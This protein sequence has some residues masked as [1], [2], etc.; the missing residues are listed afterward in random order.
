MIV[1]DEDK[2]YDIY[3]S[4]KFLYVSETYVHV[5]SNIVLG[6]GKVLIMSDSAYTRTFV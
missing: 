1:C 5:G 6:R 2:K 4:E 3:S